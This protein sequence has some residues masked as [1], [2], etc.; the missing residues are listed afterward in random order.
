[1]GQRDFGLVLILSLVA[2]LLLFV[3]L[4]I[5]LASAQWKFAVGVVNGL[6]STVLGSFILYL[7]RLVRT[8]RERKDG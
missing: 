4:H 1:V 3:Q 5:L 7:K 2:F 6:A 8:N